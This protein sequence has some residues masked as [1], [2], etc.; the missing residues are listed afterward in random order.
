[1]FGRIDP[2]LGESLVNSVQDF[3][4]SFGDEIGKKPFVSLRNAPLP[5]EIQGNKPQFV[6]LRKLE[7]LGGAISLGVTDLGLYDAGV[8]RNVFGYGSDG[9]AI[10][11]TFR[12]KRET[13]DKRHFHQRLGKEIV[14]LLAMACDLPRCQD[15]A[16]VVVYHRTMEDVDRN[17]YV[18]DTCRT[19]IAGV[20][21]HHYENHEK[22]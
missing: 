14:K 18:C 8:S 17:R 5:R 21:K 13:A 11:S 3:I 6:F 19:K 9:I 15:P 10:L 22:I 12:F 1:L 7:E 20:L 2:D 16:C 4:D